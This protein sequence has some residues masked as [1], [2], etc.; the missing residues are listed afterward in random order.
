MIA[1]G[2]GASSGVNSRRPAQEN[3]ATSE[4]GSVRALPLL[5]SKW[6]IPREPPELLDRPRLRQAIEAGLDKPVTLVSAAPGYGKTTLLSSWARR[7]VIDWPIAWF[8]VEAADV[9]HRFW[10]YLHAALGAAGVR[11][12]AGE[13]LPVPGFVPDEGYLTLLAD[14]LAG[15]ATPAVLI[16]DDFQSLTDS[17]TLDGI[18]FLVRHA[19]HRLR[20]VFSTRGVPALP[21]QRWRVHGELSEVDAAEL[22]FTGPEA[23]NLLSRAERPLSAEQ[24]GTLHDRTEG[25]AAGLRLATLSLRTAPDPDHFVHQ[26]GGGHGS[27]ADY[28]FDEVYK[29]QAAG[30]RH[31]LISS[32]VAS[33][34]CGELLDAL[35]GGT[36]G[37]R[38]LATLERTDAFVFPLGGRQGWYRYSRLFG[39]LLLAQ[40]HQE[41]SPERICELNRRAATW[42]AVSGGH[43]LAL[44]HALAGQDWPTATGVLA[45]HWRELALSGHG[46]TLRVRPVPPPRDEVRADPSLALAYAADRLDVGDHDGALT[47]LQLADSHRHLV[48]EGSREHFRQILSAFRLTEAHLRGEIAQPMPLAPRHLLDD[49]T[50]AVEEL[51]RRELTVVHYLQS[52]LTHSEIAAELSVSVHTVKT[53]VRSIYRK[54][55]VT[56]R[57]EALRRARDLRL[58]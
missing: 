20:L 16:F 52:P 47:Y 26:F 42:H 1:Q 14:A 4:T 38:L 51:S 55:G 19:G 3:E 58:L 30:D 31:M 2:G 34:I 15:S 46:D 22:A 29:P 17:R 6:A 18:V 45:A 27:V 21:L 57:R 23:S 49:S 11:G 36:G 8:T 54:L 53:H 48:D 9:G 40:L 13:D 56:R 25:W 10:S 41:A 35:A 43:M 5:A 28:L 50:L 32:A 44:R 24:L 12:R 37:E 33:R 7:T 39:D